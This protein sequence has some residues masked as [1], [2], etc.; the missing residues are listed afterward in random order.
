MGNVAIDF[1]KRFDRT[2]G[3]FWGDQPDG[4]IGSHD[5]GLIKQHGRLDPDAV[6]VKELSGLGDADFHAVTLR[7]SRYAVASYLYN[8]YPQVFAKY[9]TGDGFGNTALDARITHRELQSGGGAVQ[10]LAD[11]A[12]ALEPRDRRLLEAS[13]CIHTDNRVDARLINDGL[14]RINNP[15]PLAPLDAAFRR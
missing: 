2:G 10:F 15:K 7:M 12:A 11:V 13:R 3:G 8:K 4:E 9:D 5:T 1:I 6:F 14:A